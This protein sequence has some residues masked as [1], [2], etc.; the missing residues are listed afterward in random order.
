MVT[1]AVVGA[2]DVVTAAVVGAADVGE[3]EADDVEPG[4]VVV[5]PGRVVVD[6]GRVVV[7]PVGWSSTRSR[8]GGRPVVVR[9]VV[10]GGAA[11]N[12]VARRSSNSCS[13]DDCARA[14]V[15]PVPHSWYAANSSVST[16]SVISTRP[17]PPTHHCQVRHRRFVG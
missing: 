1:A 17:S 5:D 8:R 9:A 15:M 2:A 7:D 11:V 13:S 6:P 10:V 4:R 14:W 12:S 3:V 16:P